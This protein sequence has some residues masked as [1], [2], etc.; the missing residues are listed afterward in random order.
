MALVI[1]GCLYVLKYFYLR[2]YAVL[3]LLLG[4]C[5]AGFQSKNFRDLYLTQ[6]LFQPFRLCTS[7]SEL[8]RTP[9]RITTAERVV[10]SQIRGASAQ[11]NGAD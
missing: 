2:G 10:N 7:W 6:K 4:A 5:L 1:S 3:E 11:I 9:R 8:S